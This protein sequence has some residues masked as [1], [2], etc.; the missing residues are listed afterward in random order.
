MG[1]YIFETIQLHNFYYQEMCCFQVIA[2]HTSI[3]SV[4]F[5]L[6]FGRRR[7]V[8]EINPGRIRNFTERKSGFSRPQLCRRL[9][10]HCTHFAARVFRVD[11]LTKFQ[12]K[13]YSEI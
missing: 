1:K 3:S 9:E 2:E 6:Y 8:I 4:T 12:V 11:L 5:E 13:S 7:Y 10:Q